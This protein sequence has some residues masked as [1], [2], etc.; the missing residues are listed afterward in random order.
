M[1]SFDVNKQ[2]GN[3]DLAEKRCFQG[4]AMELN[5]EKNKHDSKHR[6]KSQFKTYKTIDLDDSR[7][8]KNGHSNQQP[9]Q[10]SEVAVQDR[11]RATEPRSPSG[12][13][14]SFG[15]GTLTQPITEYMS[16]N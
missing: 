12:P 5:I 8:S 7:M 16:R 15:F 3:R 2:V 10:Q 9:A 4:S 14:H 6:F 11:T 13:P 1:L